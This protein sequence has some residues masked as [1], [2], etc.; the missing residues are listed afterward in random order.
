MLVPPF[1]DRLGVGEQRE[2][3]VACEDPRCAEVA[4]TGLP[5]PS[6][7]TL[8]AAAWAPDGSPIIALSRP[9]S[10]VLV[11]C[12]DPACT[13]TALTEISGPLGLGSPQLDT[14]W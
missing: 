6:E 10:V 14:R 8:I 4:I 7:A 11:S 5:E 12:D 9:D 1:G 2:I 13:S 3:K